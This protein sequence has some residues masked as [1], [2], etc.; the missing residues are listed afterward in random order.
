[1]LKQILDTVPQAI[2]WKDKAGVYLGCN[3]VFPAAIGL[4]GTE[5]IIGKTDFDMPW[6]R[7]EAEVYRADDAEVVASGIPKR[8][9]VEPLQQA[10]GA[11]GWIATTKLPLLD[12]RGEINGVLGVFEDI[13]ERKEI[14]AGLERTRK[15]LA[16]IKITAD[17]VSEYAESLINTVRE[18]LIAL[19]QDLRVVTV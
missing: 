13:T 3:L 19:D 7:E 10:D 11:R 1:M 6:P 18:P 8:N 9:I 4:S 12:S 5:Q 14:E 2:F 16:V 17:A 15:E